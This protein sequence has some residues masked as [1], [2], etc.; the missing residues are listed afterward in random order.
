MKEFRGTGVALV[1]PFKTDG[2]LDEAALEKLVDWQIEQGINFLVPCGT[3]GENPA[4]TQDEHRRVVEIT[5]RRAAKRVPVL[6]GAGSNSTDKAIELARTAIDLGA[7]G[8]LTITP[9]YNKPTPDGLRRHFGLQAQAAGQFPM[10]MYNVPGRTGVN[11]DAATTLRI[12]K[13][14]PNIVG[15]KEASANM[16][17]MLTILR[18]R[19]PGFL[20]LSGDDAWTLPLIGAGGDGVISVAANEIPALMSALTKAALGGDFARAREIHNRILPLMTGNFMES[21]PIPVKTA[22]K[23]MGILENDT[24]RSP[25]APLTEANRPKLEAILRE[26]GLR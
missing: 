8:L 21:N 14:N 18:D 11:M 19:A 2:A 9:Y 25:L 4:L 22:M 5:I 16:E 24:V 23:M 15:V 6:A 26:C 20:M 12:A 17:Q 7:D 1:T 13:E 10:I 3:T